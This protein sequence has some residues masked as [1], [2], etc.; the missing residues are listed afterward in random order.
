LDFAKLST[1]ELIELLAA[2]EDEVVKL[3]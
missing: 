1:D 3:R 2:C